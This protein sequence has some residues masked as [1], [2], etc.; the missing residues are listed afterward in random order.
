MKPSELLSVAEGLVTGGD[1]ART[2]G[3][4]RTAAALGRQ[5]IEETLR[6]YWQLS[7]PGME[8]CSAHAQLLCLR[9]YLDNTGL[10]RATGAA[11]SD[12]S[13]ACHHHPY[14]LNPTAVELRAWLFAA[15]SFAVEV[16]RQ[17]AAAGPRGRN[18]AAGG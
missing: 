11:W 9:V 8:R 3:W 2:A 13:R 14:E 16:A 1:T 5:A 6:Q 7:E 18:G 10:V 15:R 17:I 4:P 12:L